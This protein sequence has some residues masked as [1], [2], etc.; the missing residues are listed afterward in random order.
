MADGA[1]P[2]GPDLGEVFRAAMARLPAGVCVVAAARRRGTRATGRT[3]RDRSAADQGAP[4][5]STPKDLVTDHAM[6]AT[7]VT[8]VS[9]EPPMLL[10]CVHGDARL[11]EVLDDVETWAVSVLDAAAVPV[12]EWLATPGRPTV[13]QLGRVAHRRGSVSG[14]AL[15]AD[16]QAWLE[17][18]TMWIRTA[19][20]HDIVVGEVLA[21]EVA[22]GAHGAL[23]HRLGRLA[24]LAD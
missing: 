9:L 10:F 4:A 23:V 14:A 21:A 18:R 15:L 2:A 22:R 13:D 24:V 17:C 16:A 3:A 11:R 7:S 5:G 8:A 12:A 6:T 1:V 20:D 19:G